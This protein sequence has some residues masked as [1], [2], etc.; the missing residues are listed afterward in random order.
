M[1]LFGVPRRARAKGIE[2]QVR[3]LQLCRSTRTRSL[4]IILGGTG[5]TAR[6][7]DSRLPP[8]RRSHR[9]RTLGRTR[10]MHQEK[11]TNICRSCQHRCSGTHYC[12]RYHRTQDTRWDRTNLT[13]CLFL[14]SPFHSSLNPN[15]MRL[16][17]NCLYRRPLTKHRSHHRPELAN[18]QDKGHRL[19][20]WTANGCYLLNCRM[21]NTN[22]HY[23]NCM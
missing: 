5:Q 2:I 10:R 6:Q 13:S 11:P 12:R 15:W 23:C 21:N 8:D 1:C 7:P 9:R 20:C 17:N 14:K 22:H 18:L 4:T 3:M 19:S 16:S